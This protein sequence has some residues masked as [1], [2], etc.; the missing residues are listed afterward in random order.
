M[1]EFS[2]E[3]YHLLSFGDK[4]LILILVLSGIFSFFLIELFTYP[5]KFALVSVNG[6]QKYRKSLA[7]DEVFTLSGPI[8]EAKVEISQ[9]AVRILEADC[10]Q[11]LCVLQGK[12]QNVGEIIVCVPNK[13][14]IWIEG[15]RKNELDAITG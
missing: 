11:K 14:S 2:K 7:V 15:R 13:V 10:P 4:I 8:G 6:E 3:I 5:G 12:I 9:G 1:N